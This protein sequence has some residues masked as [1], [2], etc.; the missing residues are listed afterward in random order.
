MIVNVKCEQNGLY[1]Q[2]EHVL[3]V[4]KTPRT[5]TWSYTA[6]EKRPGTVMQTRRFGQDEWGSFL[7]EVTFD[8]HKG[9]YC[10]TAAH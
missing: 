3:G 8:A 9:T 6:L 7:P 1:Y 4:S 2:S 5:I 10:A